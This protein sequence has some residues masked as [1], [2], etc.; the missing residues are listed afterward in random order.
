M[1]AA[2]RL[3]PSIV[4]ST[5]A[6][7]LKNVIAPQYL[8]GVLVA[9]NHAITQTWYAAVALAAVSII[10]LV[11][12]NTGLDL[13]TAHFNVWSNDVP[14]QLSPIPRVGADGQMLLSYFTTMVSHLLAPFGDDSTISQFFLRIALMDETPAS[15][16]VLQGIL[17]LSSLKLYGGAEASLFKS[18][19]ISML[20]A[21]MKKGM[22]LSEHLRCLAASLLLGW[23]KISSSTDTADGWAFFVCGATKLAKAMSLPRILGSEEVLLLDWLSCHTI[24][25]QFSTSH[26]RQSESC[27]YRQSCAED[28]QLRNVYSLIPD[29]SRIMSFLGC[30][31]EFL[32]I[33]SLTCSAV[34]PRSH[35]NF[36]SGEHKQQLDSLELRLISIRRHNDFATT[37]PRE[38]KRTDLVAELYRLA[39]LVYLHRG[40]RRSRVGFQPTENVLRNA[41]SIIKQLEYCESTTYDGSKESSDELIN[42]RPL[43]SKPASNEIPVHSHCPPHHLT[44]QD[45][46]QS[47]PNFA[48]TAKK[49]DSAKSK[50]KAKIDVSCVNCDFKENRD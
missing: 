38:Q 50:T 6:T 29:R 21:S 2:L 18:K 19:A 44:Q 35:P 3:S 37:T 46:E 8:P 1:P 15:S 23:Y 34:L 40:G 13:H 25:A 12:L 24:L 27:V 14:G 7:A 36:L 9:Y 4:S 32:D 30:S 43:L 48:I 11:P 5:G 22:H 10:G 45:L 33:L 39:G 31:L 26:W 47:R 49:C 41:F 28:P 16:A 17:A 20:A 42:H